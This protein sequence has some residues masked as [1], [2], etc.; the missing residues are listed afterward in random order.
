MRRGLGALNPYARLY[1]PE[2]SLANRVMN[3]VPSWADA[4]WTA[5]DPSAAPGAA[6]AK[7][8]SA[9]QRTVSM[10]WEIQAIASFP[11]AL[12]GVGVGILNAADDLA[13]GGAAVAQ[14]ARQAA[15]QADDDRIRLYR[16]VSLEEFEDIMKTGGRL[17][18]KLGH[19]EGKWFTVSPELA[20]R[21]G[22]IFWKWQRQPYTIIEVVVR[23]R[24]LKHM[25]YDD[26]LDFIGPAYYA[27]QRLLPHVRFMREMP[28]I[29]WIP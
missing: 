19:M 16:A 2:S 1:R 15:R 24:L 21:W 20:A 12:G 27:E 22:K 25:H 23:R 7:A 29:P 11:R 28:Y 9:L 6:F 14:G 13:G 17:R 10:A 3:L 26:K 18:P 5:G 4:G 8:V